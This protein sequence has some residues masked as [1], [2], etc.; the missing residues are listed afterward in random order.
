MNIAVAH[1]AV[2]PQC[3]PYHDCYESQE[4]EYEIVCCLYSKEKKKIY[5]K[6]RI[7]FSLAIK[8]M[9]KIQLSF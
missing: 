3:M 8:G 9:R 4:T 7:L 6:D 5:N 2:E 1:P